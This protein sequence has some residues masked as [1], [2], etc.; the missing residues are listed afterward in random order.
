MNQGTSFGAAFQ[1]I[2]VMFLGKLGYLQDAQC[3]SSCK[4]CI[5]PW[6]QLELGD[7]IRAVRPKHIAVY[8]ILGKLGHPQTVSSASSCELCAHLWLQLELRK[9]ITFLVLS[10]K[11][12]C[13][14]TT[15][16]FLRAGSCPLCGTHVLEHAQTTTRR[17]KRKRDRR[18]VQ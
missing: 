4:L 3:A 6:S 17:T 1:V 11:G 16:S 14:H 15:F 9:E 12:S 10:C 13:L 18:R 8:M 5:Q 7:K 2:R